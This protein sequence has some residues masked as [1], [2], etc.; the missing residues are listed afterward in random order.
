MN[1]LL[2]QSVSVEQ[3]LLECAMLI[4]EFGP[5][6]EE[7]DHF[8]ES[9]RDR[10]EFVELANLSRRLKKVLEVKQAHLTESN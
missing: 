10:T 7:V 8:I 5:D 6:S 3:L 2:A 1:D 4:N 9:H